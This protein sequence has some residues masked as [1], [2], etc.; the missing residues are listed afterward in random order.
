MFQSLRV[1]RLKGCV[2]MFRSLRYLR[3][4]RILRILRG[5]PPEKT[6]F[7]LVPLKRGHLFIFARMLL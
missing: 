1:E 3:I 7:F 4:L 5:T 2:R 6:L